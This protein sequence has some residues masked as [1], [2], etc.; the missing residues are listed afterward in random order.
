M[1]VYAYSHSQVH[2]Q[3][4]PYCYITLDNSHYL[5]HRLQLLLIAYMYRRIEMNRQAA[6]RRQEERKRA[7]EAATMETGEVL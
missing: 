2:V 3:Y 6:I 7:V 4:M 1:L 5:S